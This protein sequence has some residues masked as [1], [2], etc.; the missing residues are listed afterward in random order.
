[1]TYLP[2]SVKLLQFVMIFATN[3]VISHAVEIQI[4]V[5]SFVA[6]PVLP[7]AG[8]RSSFTKLMGL[9]LVEGYSRCAKFQ[10]FKI[11][12]LLQVLKLALI[13]A[14]HKKLVIRL[15]WGYC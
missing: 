10:R 8:R 5:F 12:S 9:N 15:I 4:F 2:K 6:I 14:R 1:M 7:L 13:S 3:V 11:S